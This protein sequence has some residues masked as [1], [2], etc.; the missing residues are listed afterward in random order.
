MA[1]TKELSPIAIKQGILKERNRP[2]LRE[3]IPLIFDDFFELHG[4][5]QFSDDQAILGGLALVEGSPVTVIGHV[6][7]KS[8]R[9]NIA[10]NFGMAHP[11][12]YRKALRLMKQAEK[13][14]RPVITFID[15]SGAFC[16][17]GAEERGQGEAIARNLMEMMALNVPVIALVLG[18]GGSGGA[19]GIAVANQVYM[20]ENA[21]YSVISPKGCASILWKDASRE[22]EAAELL[23][24]TAR[25]LLSMGIIDGILPEPEGG[26]QKNVKQVALRIRSTLIQAIQTL[27]REPE[28]AVK[29]YEKFRAMGV[30]EQ[31]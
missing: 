6:K 13:F 20:L 5:R 31:V 23:K 29:R 24:M 4:D 2:T 7:G 10:S 12:G 26:A 8:T 14:G 1:S 27:E 22:M 16:G 17:I 25:D 9:E 15:T 28:L 19:L 30:F 21:L 18:E 3:Y 11:E